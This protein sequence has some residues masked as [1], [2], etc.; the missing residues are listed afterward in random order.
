MHGLDEIRTPKGIRK[1]KTHFGKVLYIH[2]LD[3]GGQ[4]G[5]WDHLCKAAPPQQKPRDSEPVCL[6]FQHQKGHWVQEFHAATCGPGVGVDWRL[7]RNLNLV[8]MCVKM[9]HFGHV[10]LLF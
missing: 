6:E 2:K 10:I 9:Y 8:V 3:R 5:W 7:R 4:E 1:F